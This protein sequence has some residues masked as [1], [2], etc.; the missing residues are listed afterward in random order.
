MDEVQ[1]PE[2]CTLRGAPGTVVEVVGEIHFLQ[3]AW[4]E[5]SLRFVAKGSQ[6]AAL[7][8][9]SHRCLD[10]EGSL[11]FLDPDV[12]FIDCGSDS[13]DDGGAFYVEQNVTLSNGRVVARG[14]NAKWGAAAYVGGSFT[15]TGGSLLIENST[16]GESGGG[17]YVKDGD[18]HHL[19]GNVTMLNSIAGIYGGGVYMNRGKYHLAGYLR[20]ENCFATSAGGGLQARNFQRKNFGAFNQTPSGVLEAKNCTAGL[21]YGE[22]G[23]MA[24][25]DSIIAGRVLV[26]GCRGSTAG[27]F[28]AKREPSWELPRQCGAS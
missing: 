13:T 15:M 12:E 3:N 23:V 7:P 19:G 4:L 14:S 16:A 21:L 11:E 8:M 26:D 5:G 25:Q 6:K 17:L 10:V 24:T 28:E 22:G 27:C 18:F 1:Y 2:D 9:G 20:F